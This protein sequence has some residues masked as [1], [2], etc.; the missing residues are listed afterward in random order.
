MRIPLVVDQVE[1]NAVAQAVE[2]ALR[3]IVP[4]AALHALT[5]AVRESERWLDRQSL[6][7]RCGI[8]RRTLHRRLSAA[9]LGSPSLVLAWG[10]ILMTCRYQDRGLTLEQVAHRHGLSGSPALVHL[11]RQHAGATPGSLRTAGGLTAALALLRSRIAVHRSARTNPVQ[12][13]D[14]NVADST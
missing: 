14:K 7:R 5:I 9:G 4:R 6:A 13:V 11:F 2:L 3:G 12:R 8:P 1:C 10:H